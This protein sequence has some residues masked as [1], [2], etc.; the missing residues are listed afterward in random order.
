MREFDSQIKQMMPIFHQKNLRKGRFSQA[1]QIYHI[2]SATISRE[3]IFQELQA[4]R[5]LINILRD[6]ERQQHAHTFAFVVM[7]DHFHWLMQLGGTQ[8]LSL[9]VRTVKARTSHRLGQPIWQQGFYDHALRKDEDIQTAARYIIANPLRA[10]LVQHIGD[11]PH[12]DAVW[13]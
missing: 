11:Y 7:P 10:G 5:C 6:A 8:S 4:A 2:T 1:A 9:I 3:P 12:W 13:L